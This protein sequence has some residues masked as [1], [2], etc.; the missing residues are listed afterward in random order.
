LRPFFA[1]RA[2]IDL[3]LM[4]LCPYKLGKPYPLGQCL[5]ISQEAQQMLKEVDPS[6]LT[7]KTAQTGYLAY[8]HFAVPVVRYG[9]S[10]AICV[11]VFSERFSVGES[12]CRR[13]Q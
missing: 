7:D 1:V 9:R 2:Q 4:P 11:G 10:G 8:R 13:F 3:K 6:I 12:V 5:E